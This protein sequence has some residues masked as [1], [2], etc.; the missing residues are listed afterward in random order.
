LQK[1]NVVAFVCR[2][3]AHDAR[4]APC[5]VGAASQDVS[6]SI[7]LFVTRRGDSPTLVGNILANYD[8]EIAMNTKALVIGFIISTLLAAASPAISQDAPPL[9]EQAKQT[10]ALVEKAAALIDKNGRAAFNEFRK[11]DSEWFHGTTYLYA[12]DL[13]GNVLLNPAFPG[14]E[15]TNVNGQKDAKGKLF[16]NE[17]IKTAETKGSGWVD[18]MFPKPGQTEPSQKWAYVRE[19]TIDGVPGLV[20]S[21]FYPQ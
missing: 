8:R 9:S 20:A 15:G 6:F 5:C 3:R 21:G 7:A 10:K 11:K 14:R 1:F 18:Y 19:V 12:Y 13:K 2:R 17:I 4:L 16:H